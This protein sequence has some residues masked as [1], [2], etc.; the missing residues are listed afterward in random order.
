MKTIGLLGGMSW[1]STA[2]YYDMI[3]LEISRRLGGLNSGKIAM[4]SVN[5]DEIEKLQHEGK[6]D[7]L[8]EIL[9]DS[10][11]KVEAAGADFLVLCTNTMHKVADKI[12]SSINIPM[13][14][15]AEATADVV[16]KNRFKKVGL[17]GTKFT[18]EQ[19]FYK[20]KLHDRYIDVLIP[21][22]KDIKIVHTV[23]YNE[24]CAGKVEDAS[25]KEYLRIINDLASKGAEAVILGCTEIGMLVKQEDTAIPLLDTTII[26][27]K[28]AVDLALE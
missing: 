13:L 11:K 7:E 25:K 14:H 8:G 22:K 28:A 3:N 27:A 15:I 26:H 19:Y 18:M 9:S 12:E 10:A 23:I 1:E 4:F 16:Q 17:L 21:E 6:W 20:G 5:F 24:L 2:L